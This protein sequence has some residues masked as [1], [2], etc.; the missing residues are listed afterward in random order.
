MKITRGLIKSMMITVA[1]VAATA[2]A[3]AEKMDAEIHTVVIQKLERAL[4]EAKEDETV[5]LRPVRA[6][7]ADLYA[8]RARLRAMDEAE[9]NCDTCTGAL[10][11]RKRALK[12]Y[13]AV[14]AEASKENRGPLMLQMAQ[15]R[16]LNN[17]NKAALGLYE[18]LIKE[19]GSKHKADILAE[20]LIGRAEARFGRGD[21]DGAQR[22]FES[23][24]KLVGSGRKGVIMHRIAW[25]ELN[26]GDQNKAVRSLIHIL[27]TPAL[28]TRESSEGPKFDVSFQEDV[29]RDLATFLARGE[30]TSR[31]IAMLENLAPER[32]KK[33]TMKHFASECERLGQKKAAISAW[34]AVAKYESKSSDRLEALVRVA[35]IRF[36]L[37]QKKEALAG[38]QQATQAWTKGGCDDAEVC[39]NLETR[40]RELVIAW[41]KMEKKKPSGLLADAY[42]AYLSAFDGDIEMTEWAAE[43][44]RAQKRF[45]LAATLYHKASQLAAAAP[46][47]KHS[48][49]V[50]ESAVVGEVEM[51]ELSKDN[52]TREASYD[53]YLALNANGAIAAKI[54]YQR[55]HVAYERGDMKEA[56]NRFHAFAVSGDCRTSRAKETSQLCVQAADLDLDA[57]VGLKEH[58]LVQIRAAEYGQLFSSRRQEYTKIARTAVMKQAE[59]EEPAQALAKLNEA[60]LNGASSDD[61]VRLFKTRIALAEKAHDL[62]ET[63][64]SAQ[65]LLA[66]KGLSA[67][68]REFALGKIAWAAEMVLDFNEAYKISRQMRFSSLGKDERAMKLALLAELSGHDSR[69]HEEEFLKVS[70][71]SFRKAFIRAKMVRGARNP[72]K[73]LAKHESALRAY[74][75]LYAQLA[76]EIYAKTGDVGFAARAL[77]VRGVNRDVAGL[78]LAREIFLKDFSKMDRLIASH[79]LRSSSDA[80][81]KKSLAE[82]LKLL[83]QADRT[84]NQAIASHDWALQL[85]ALTTLSRENR[86]VY[87]DIIALPVPK[88]LKGQARMTYM[89]MVESSARSYMH[90][91][92]QID[93]KLT[94][95]WG[96]RAS[97]D[98]LTGGYQTVRRELR[99]ILAGEIRRLAQIA[100]AAIRTELLEQL[101]NGPQTPSDQQVLLA[102]KEAKQQPFSVQTISKL[103]ELEVGRG[104]ETMVAYLD[105]RLLKLK[106]GEKR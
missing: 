98:A 26:R 4:S 71:D 3:R 94:L 30:V 73:E 66:T 70:R 76:L 23:A 21:T 54:R 90:K 5:S 84:A 51:A 67:A 105:M 41:N 104:R 85:V 53:H 7:L 6:R 72:V 80:V 9:K 93:K 92:D 59:N 83:S 99:P 27:Q 44:A 45:G 101:Q 74:P 10:E 34:A 33:E 22:D 102:R 103:R 106:T 77:K 64:R 40:M 81:M 82:R 15:L 91:S 17:E 42:V 29:A 89:Q 88:K 79:R 36:D 56:S 87:N 1:A 43:A 16:E 47:A 2:T 35:Q 38:L 37:D 96:D 61:R 78:L 46:K 55:A 63:H 31:E 95:L 57:L 39:K 68:D 25:C 14:V 12:L 18:T 58:A 49:E 32:A 50:L 100:P 24:L 62:N 8:E 86:R 69:P 65:M 48:K 60:D 20:A 52:R 75:S 19:G 11:D 97:E 28:L 13:D